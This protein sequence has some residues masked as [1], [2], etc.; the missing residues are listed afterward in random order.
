MVSTYTSNTGIEKPATG[1]Q[2]G[3]WGDTVNTNMD[4]LDRAVNGIGTISLS[5]TTHT[6]TTTD[7]TLSDGMY[8][9]LVLGGSPSGTN[10]ITI[11]PNDAQKLY[12]VINGSGQDA[13][14]TQGS[15]A[16]VT[17]ADGTTK[18]IYADGAGA[19]AAV[20]DVT[21][22]FSIGSGVFAG[23]FSGTATISGGSVSGITD[24]AIADGGTGASNEADARSN[25]GLGTMAT[26]AA[27]NVA[28]TGG[29]IGGSV[30]LDGVAANTLL[31]DTDISSTVQ[32]YNADT[33]FAD[34]SDNLT[35]GYTNT[36][37]DYGTISSGTVTVDFTEAAQAYYTNNGAHTLAP[38]TGV[39]GGQDIL[40]TN[41]ASAGAI[42]TSGFTNVV[43]DSFDTINGNKFL[44]QVRR[45][46]SIDALIIT[47]LQ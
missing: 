6:L 20:V 4:I 13:I 33:L 40:I 8:K 28:I 5:G 2:S 23:T 46:N 36:A 27:S 32:P 24:L 43:G 22:T 19:G 44:A 16:N 21:S 14:F 26:Q 41:G 9:V 7:G 1:E 37:H 15:G 11:S 18:I 42:T 45:I 38:D 12:F 47:A 34:V 31:N 30:T 17:V 10:T 25:L 29:T 39:E 3:T 35:A